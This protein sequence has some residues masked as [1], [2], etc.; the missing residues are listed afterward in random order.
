MKTAIRKNMLLQM[1][2]LSES[3]IYSLEQKGLFPKRFALTKRAVAW[4]KEEVEN[5]LKT[6]QENNHRHA[7][8]T[9]QK[10][11]AKAPKRSGNKI[12]V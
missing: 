8:N 12:S 4:D 10:N 9:V 5:W 1:V 11:L 7:D 2:P 3:T 6:R